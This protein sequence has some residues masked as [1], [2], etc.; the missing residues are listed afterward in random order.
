M[1]V[2]LT[3]SFSGISL[4]DVLEFLVAQ[5]V[6]MA[7]GAFVFSWHFRAKRPTLTDGLHHPRNPVRGINGPREML[8]RGRLRV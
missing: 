6:G 4:W 7:V 2:S 3:N 5:M 8:L 1:A